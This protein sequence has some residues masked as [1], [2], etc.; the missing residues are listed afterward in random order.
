MDHNPANTALAPFTLV[1]GGVIGVFK[2]TKLYGPSQ[3]KPN[4]WPEIYEVQ[5]P[6]WTSRPRQI[7]LLFGLL[8]AFRSVFPPF[9]LSAHEQQ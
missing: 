3:A 8:L 5:V 9:R 1:Q 2:L 6:A 4:M 7:S